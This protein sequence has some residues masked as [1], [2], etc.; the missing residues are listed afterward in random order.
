MSRPRP[1]NDHTEPHYT[2]ANHPEN[3]TTRPENPHPRHTHA[4]PHPD[5][6][7][8]AEFLLTQPDAHLYRRRYLELITTTPDPG[9]TTHTDYTTA[10][11]YLLTTATRRR[12]TLRTSTPQPAETAHIDTLYTPARA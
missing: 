10:E 7:A 4:T 8:A 6:I 5:V 2:T 9:G 12:K 1:D 3:N 11:N